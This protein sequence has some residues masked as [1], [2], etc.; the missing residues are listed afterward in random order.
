MPPIHDGEKGS[1]RSSIVSYFEYDSWIHDESLD[2][3]HEGGYHPVVLWDTFK[4]GR[5]TIRHKLERKMKY[6]AWVAR[7]NQ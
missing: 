4:D 1:S 2:P 6:T 5:Y 7:D 3:Y